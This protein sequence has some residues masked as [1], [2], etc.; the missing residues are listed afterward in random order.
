MEDVE[1][2]WFR[3]KAYNL[4]QPSMDRRDSDKHYTFNNCRFIEIAKNTR[5]KARGE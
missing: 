4:K 5:R 3:D 1:K 2:L